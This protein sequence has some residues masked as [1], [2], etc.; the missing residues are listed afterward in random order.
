VRLIK[1]KGKDSIAAVVS[2]AKS[3]EKPDE[4]ID[5]YQTTLITDAEVATTDTE[6][7][8]TET[9]TETETGTDAE[10]GTGTINE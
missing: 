9:N 6:V 8:P 3:E 10:G 4:N 2:V 1:L 7:A 5:E